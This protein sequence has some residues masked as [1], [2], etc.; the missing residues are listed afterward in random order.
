M[1]PS[2]NDCFF[3]LK[4]ID[5][6]ITYCL[7]HKLWNEPCPPRCGEITPDE[8]GSI[9]EV[10]SNNYDID[11]IDFTRRKISQNYPAYF[12]ETYNQTEPFCHSCLF[13]RYLVYPSDLK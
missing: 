7:K 3:L 12:C 8:P 13:H 6:S 2:F 5:D 10:Q 11:C 1:T 4:S 9:E